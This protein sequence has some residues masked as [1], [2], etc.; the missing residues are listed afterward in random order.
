MVT[1]GQALPFAEHFDG[2]LFPPAGW[3]AQG[4]G[5]VGGQGGLGWQGD[6]TGSCGMNT[7]AYVAAYTYT[8]YFA[9]PMLSSPRIDLVQTP[10]PYLAF[11]WSYAPES[12]T[13]TE[14]FRVYA[15]DCAGSVYAQVVQLSSAQ[16]ASNGG[17]AQA[18]PAWVPTACAHWRTRLTSLAPVQGRTA[19]LDFRLDTQGGQN[20]FLDD[21]A[22]FAGSRLA[23][24]LFLEG[25]YQSGSG[26]MSDA[27]RTQG[28]V[29]LSEPFTAAGHVFAGEGGGETTT[30][31]VLS[32]TGAAA[33]VD[34]VLVEMRDAVDPTKVITS[35]AALVRR[36][37]QVVDLDGVSH[38][39]VGVPAGSYHVAV[40]HRNHLGAMTAAPV[41]VGTGMALL[42]FTAPATPTWG[43][44]ARKTIGTACVLWSGDVDR[45]GT[46]QYTG[47]GNDRD[48]ILGAIGGVVPTATVSGYLKEDCTLDG[49]VK[50]TG[51]DNDRERILQNI[52]G[53]VPTN[54][55]VQQLP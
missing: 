31:G 33:V 14:T 9:A 49:V 5:T 46:I 25:P 53:V 43:T 39:R 16:L 41:A 22:V 45:N 51:T 3:I 47:P 23:L 6:A 35:R 42:D 12:S 13:N 34:W 37:G 7:S 2:G 50:Y 48:P 1:G 18:A 15:H 38:V 55:R 20:F 52:G 30:P 29:P 27:L 8:G 44:A 24:K 54:T 26:S 36:D 21:I 40:R 17:T 4:E 10:D 32:V 28:L 19:V 11:T